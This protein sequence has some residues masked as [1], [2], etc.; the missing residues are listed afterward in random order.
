MQLHPTAISIG[1]DFM[2][3][4]NPLTVQINVAGKTADVRDLAVSVRIKGVHYFFGSIGKVGFDA[5]ESLVFSVIIDQ[6]DIFIV[7]GNLIQEIFADFSKNCNCGI[8]SQCRPIL[9]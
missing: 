2:F 8:I 7:V 1:A 3:T 5:V 9:F 4:R 6:D